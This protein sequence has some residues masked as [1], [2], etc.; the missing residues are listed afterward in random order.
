MLLSVDFNSSLIHIVGVGDPWVAELVDVAHALGHRCAA[1]AGRVIDTSYWRERDCEVVDFRDLV[2]SSFVFTGSDFDPE[3]AGAIYSKYALAPF[4]SLVK[5][6]EEHS[7]VRWVNLVHPM[8]WV[9]PSALLAQDIFV[10]ANSSIGANSVIGAHGRVNR[11]VSIGHD[12]VLGDGIEIAPGAV[13]SSGVVVG[14]WAFIGAGAVVLNSVSI[15]SGATVGAGSV[16][17]KNVG[18]GQVV[19]GVP[20]T[21]R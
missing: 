20:A 2:S 4:R 5:L 1:V 10:G 16:V 6:Q 8:A 12:V 9:S 13:L 18:D 17:T 21:V 3:L 19:F 15:G 11:N 7:L 14:D